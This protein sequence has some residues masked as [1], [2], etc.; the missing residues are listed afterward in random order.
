M[1][2][3]LKSVM[4]EFEKIK[5]NDST[6]K[7][8]ICSRELISNKFSLDCGHEYHYECI[9]NWFKKT[10]STMHSSK[11]REC[12]YCRKQSNYLPLK[13]GY[14][15]IKHLHD[16][17]HQPIQKI[18]PCKGVTKNGLQCKL[19]GVNGYCNIHKNKL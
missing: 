2:I 5:V 18:T 6:N 14:S 7:C 9:Y 8:T 16:P 12:P 10:V 17:I 4:D 3:S 19:K 11:N 15:Y 13:E 1:A